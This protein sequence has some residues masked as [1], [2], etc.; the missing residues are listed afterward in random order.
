MAHAAH[1][2]DPHASEGDAH[3]HA[4]APGDDLPPHGHRLEEPR[5][6]VWLPVAGLVLLATV[7]VW[8]LS[9]PSDAEEEAAAAAASASASA[10]AV[11]SAPSSMAQPAPPPL[12]QPT[13]TAN[14]A[15][16]RPP[17]MP[18]L[19][20]GM[21]MAPGAAINPKFKKP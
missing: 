3:A 6:P 21:Q 15:P 18:P 7:L 9:T 13:L 10:S 14:N 16:P 8:W 5:S 1:E 4:A 2:P 11:A 20:S 19:P 12:P 17:G